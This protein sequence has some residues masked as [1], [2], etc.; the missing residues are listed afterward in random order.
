MTLDRTGEPLDDTPPPD[1]DPR[2]VDGWIDNDH[3]PA[4]PCLTCK[5]HLARVVHRHTIGDTQ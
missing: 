2:C 4:I 1:H 3:I 5:P